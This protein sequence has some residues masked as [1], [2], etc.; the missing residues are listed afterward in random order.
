MGSVRFPI[1]VSLDGYAAGPNQSVDDPLGEGGMHLHD[2]VFGLKFF[3]QMQGIGDDGETGVNDDILR[4]TF[5]NVGATVM[6]RNM[7]GGGPGP[8]TEPSWNGW[9]G[10]DPPYHTDVFVLTHH[11][12]EPLKMEGGTTFFFVT[13]GI[14]PAMRRAKESAGDKDVIVAGGASIAQQALAAGLVDE[15]ELHVVPIVLGAGERLLDNVGALRL[16]PIRLVEDG[17]IAHLK[18]KVLH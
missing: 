10:E 14:E 3:R 7:F 16:E 4:E 11:A 12:R 15:M 1:S 18:Y 5:A 17:G 2:W 13:D 9:W 8:W 6:G